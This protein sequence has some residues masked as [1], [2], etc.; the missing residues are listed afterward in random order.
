MNS[1]S[2]QCFGG[3]AEFFFRVVDSFTLKIDVVVSSETLLIEHLTTQRH[4]LEGSNMHRAIIFI[5]GI[6]IL[7][8]VM[9]SKKSSFL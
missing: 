8:F 5:Y 2:H 6:E 3:L 4:F 7:T 1:S 9:E